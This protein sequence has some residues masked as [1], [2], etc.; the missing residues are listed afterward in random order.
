M[1]LRIQG[2][3]L[4]LRITPSEM[5]RLMEKG[6]IAETIHFG[7]DDNARLTYALEHGEQGQPIAVRQG[8]QE[9]AVVISL[10]DALRW[11]STTEIGLYGEV[12]TADGRLSVAIEKDFACLDK[13]DEENADR[14][15]N[16]S[17]GE[18]C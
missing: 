1:K 5:I 11:S 9:I 6:R 3:S 16:P 13:S 14:F 4:R 15:Q 12:P 17:K 7:V 18:T 10:R 2:N 8:T